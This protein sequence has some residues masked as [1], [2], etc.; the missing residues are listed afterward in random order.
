MIAA[1]TATSL[2]DTPVI[3]SKTNSDASSQP[4]RLSRH[5][6]AG[7]FSL[8][9]SRPL[10]IDAVPGVVIHVHSG[11]LAVSRERYAVEYVAHA[12]ERLQFHGTGP[13]VLRALSRVE[14]RVEWPPET[15]KSILPR[16]FSLSAAA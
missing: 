7:P 4:M 12:G 16:F 8:I 9:D 10:A 15:R 13:I 1:M 2:H 11:S 3:A 14:L 5:E 6:I